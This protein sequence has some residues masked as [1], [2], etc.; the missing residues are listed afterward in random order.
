MVPVCDVWVGMEPCRDAGKPGQLCQHAGFGASQQSPFV[1]LHS[2]FRQHCKCPQA[3]VPLACSCSGTGSCR[4]WCCQLPLCTRRRKPWPCWKLL[5]EHLCPCV[6]L[7]YVC[8]YQGCGSEALWSPTALSKKCKYTIRDILASP[9]VDP[10][11]WASACRMDTPHTLQSHL[12]SICIC[13]TRISESSP[14]GLEQ[15]ARNYF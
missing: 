3:S 14:Q 13:I 9:A 1:R 7:Q 12:V 5:I 10:H 8:T 11:R 4:F 15:G 6:M 2:D